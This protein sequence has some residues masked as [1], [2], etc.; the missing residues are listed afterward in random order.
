MPNQ[1][2]VESFQFLRA[3]HEAARRDLVSLLERMSI[4]TLA[5]VLPGARMVEAYGELNEDWLPTLRVR[6]VLDAVGQVLYDVD[7][8]RADHAVE[9]AIDTVNAEYLDVLVDLT[10]DEYMGA[11]TIG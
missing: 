8:G 6:R 10:G 4:E 2:L 9:S 7:G 3:R 1:Q 11:V 5:D